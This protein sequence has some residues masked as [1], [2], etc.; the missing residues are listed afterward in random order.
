MSEEKV[1]Q[2]TE[3]LKY[4]LHDFYLQNQSEAKIQLIWD[5]SMK[6]SGRRLH[7]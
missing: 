3:N 1:H 6:H 4:D 7:N 5:Y 2:F